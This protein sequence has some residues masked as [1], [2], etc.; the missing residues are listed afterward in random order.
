MTPAQEQ[1]PES[2]D[3]RFEAEAIPLLDQVYGAALSMT[4]NPTDAEDLVQETYERAY[5]SFGQFRPGTNLRA[6]LHRILTNT[7][8]NHY[9][10]RRRE[11]KQV[12]TGDIED[13]QQA[14]AESHLP[15]GL[16]SAEA[17]ALERLPSSDIQEAMNALPD[18]FRIA[19]YLADVE[20]FSYREIAESMGTPLGTVMSRLHRGRRMLRNRLEHYAEEYGMVPR[21]VAGRRC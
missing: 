14:G 18:D 1:A 16:P 20:G 17:E 6:W 8:I 13:W 4:R 10:K 2:P 15:V 7:Y 5:R 3:E 12:G 11:P 21:P 19:V 9:R